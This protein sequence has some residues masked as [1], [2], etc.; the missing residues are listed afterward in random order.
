M[1]GAGTGQSGGGLGI[2]QSSSA[3]PDL[4]DLQ[5]LFILT[6]T[7]VFQ[8][9]LLLLAVL[10]HSCAP[11]W[12]KSIWMDLHSLPCFQA[13]LEMLYLPA[14]LTNAY[15]AKDNANQTA[16]HASDH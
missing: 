4:L 6:L 9:S 16:F 3:D 15:P 1:H 10:Q 11:C 8:S 2:T 7:W 13:A 14:A 5:M 12:E